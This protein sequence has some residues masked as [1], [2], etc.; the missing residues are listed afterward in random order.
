MLTKIYVKRL[1]IGIIFGVLLYAKIFSVRCIN[2]KY[3]IIFMFTLVF[4]VTLYTLNI[5]FLYVHIG[6]SCSPIDVKYLVI[7]MFTLVLRVAL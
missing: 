1:E 7:Y 3:F 5:L 6:T 2:A 4:S